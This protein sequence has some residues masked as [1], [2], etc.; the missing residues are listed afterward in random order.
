[1][2]G[3]FLYWPRLSSWS[4]NAL[5]VNQIDDTL[6]SAANIIVEKITVDSLGKVR[7]NLSARRYKLGCLCAGLGAGC[8]NC[9]QV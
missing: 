1:M 8:G 4:V 3:I 7:L 2:G 9:K 5:L 6:E